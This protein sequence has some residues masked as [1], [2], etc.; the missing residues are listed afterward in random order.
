M[1]GESFEKGVIRIDPAP[2]GLEIVLDRNEGFNLQGDTPEPRTLADDVDD[3][4]VAVGLEIADSEA[5]DF[6]FS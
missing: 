4:L 1:F 5:A 6:S 2:V 3:G